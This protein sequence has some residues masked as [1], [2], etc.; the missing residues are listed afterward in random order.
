MTKRDGGLG[1]IIIAL[2]LT[3]QLLMSVMRWRIAAQ[4]S[5]YDYP[6]RAWSHGEEFCIKMGDTGW[7]VEP[8]ADVRARMEGR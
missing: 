5:Q 6:H 3:L 7:T 4:C 1:T 2:A 8:L